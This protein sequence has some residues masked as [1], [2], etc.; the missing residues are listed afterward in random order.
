MEED[1]Q[2]LIGVNS[3]MIFTFLNAD[4]ERKEEADSIED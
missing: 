1:V 3:L 4:Q 2:T